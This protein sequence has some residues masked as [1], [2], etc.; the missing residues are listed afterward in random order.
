MGHTLRPYQCLGISDLR[1]EIGTGKKLITLVSP[2][3]GGKT[4]IMKDLAES[5]T[6]KKKQTAIYTNRRLLLDQ[7]AEVFGDNKVAYG[8]MAAGH[9]T[10]KHAP[11]QICSVDTIRSRVFDSQTWELPPADL[12]MIDE[13]HRFNNNTGRRVIEEHLNNGAVVV[14]FTATPV[15]ID[16]ICQSLVNAG[17][18][19]ELISDDFLVPCEV[20]APSEVDMKGVDMSNG[21]FNTKQMAKRVMEC[22]IFGDVLQHWLRL[23]PWRKPTMLFAP[24]V[25]ESIYFMEK[26]KENGIKTAH[27][28]GTT[29]THER[30]EIKEASRNGEI[31]I[32]CNCEVLTFGVN[33]PWVECCILLH[34]CG[35]LTK[36]IQI[37]GRILRP[38]PGKTSAILI[39]HTGAWHRHGPPDMDRVWELG[40]T[41]LSLNQERRK[42]FER[43]EV[44]ESCCPSCGRTFKGQVCPSCN[45]KSGRSVRKIRQQD[46]T[47]KIMPGPAIK[48][49][50]KQTDKQLWSGYLFRGAQ[51]R[52]PLTIR[53]CVGMFYREQGHW[54]PDHI[55]PKKSERG[56]RVTDYYGWL[57][58]WLKKRRSK[59]KQ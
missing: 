23:N 9:N 59:Q 21:E 35:G 32:V 51:C 43:G 56:Q 50:T 42:Q 4:V 58:K 52:P 7:T 46:G 3:G 22:N 49:K 19:S 20:F 2:T 14:G 38:Y 53:Q 39:D 12:V 27:L 25:K 17:T 18:Y 1:K 26:L 37:A 15:G 57:N 48:R 24:G 31:E 45:D 11:V 16:E 47:L 8:I 44:M 55:L 10:N 54:P 29:P 13:I 34:V 28:D 36:Y 30:E 41:D 33:W 40:Q 5:T 6:I